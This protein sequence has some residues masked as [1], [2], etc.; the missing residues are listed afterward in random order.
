MHGQS[1]SHPQ[2]NALRVAIGHAHSPATVDEF[3]NLSRAAST[4][5]SHSRNASVSPGVMPLTSDPMPAFH[6][7][8]VKRERAF[9]EMDALRDCKH[10]QNN[11]NNRDFRHLTRS[12]PLPRSIPRVADRGGLG[13]VRRE[14]DRVQRF[15]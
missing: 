13:S 6:Q 8:G 9:A 7:N 12:P 10:S 11:N 1:G 4:M 3:Y 14:G 2:I 15:S 5:S